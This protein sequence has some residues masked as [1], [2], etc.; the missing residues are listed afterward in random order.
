MS[1][2]FAFLFFFFFWIFTHRNILN[3]KIADFIA[4]EAAI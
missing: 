2:A 1:F 3:N 4:K